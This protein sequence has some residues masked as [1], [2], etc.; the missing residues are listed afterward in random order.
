MKPVTELYEAAS[1]LW[2]LVAVA[3]AR[4][5]ERLR[6]AAEGLAEQQ[7]QVL[8]LVATLP[9]ERIE[10]L[11]EWLDEKPIC[12][13]CCN[14]GHAP[15]C[16]DASSGGENGAKA[17]DFPEKCGARRPNTGGLCEARMMVPHREHYAPATNEMWPTGKT[18]EEPYR[19]DQTMEEL[20]AARERMWLAMGFPETKPTAT[21][22]P[23]GKPPPFLRVGMRLWDPVTRPLCKWT[24]EVLEEK[25]VVARCEHG[26]RFG[27]PLDS[28]LTWPLAEDF[29]V[30][31]E[32]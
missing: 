30:E 7:L 5:A 26:S 12:P 31:G 3:S 29:A 28:M 4:A 17:V 18:P 9:P 1:Q 6:L 15:G 27:F 21:I 25:E 13:T 24:I 10:A 19:T 8:D 23:T 11:K 16:E 14:R 22:L 32:S 20:D 2:P